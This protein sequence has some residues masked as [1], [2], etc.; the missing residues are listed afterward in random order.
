MKAL[1]FVCAL[2][3]ALVALPTRSHAGE[4]SGNY[5]N[6][7][8]LSDGSGGGGCAGTM[9]SFRESSD[10]SA[11]AHFFEYFYG[12]GQPGFGFYAYVNSRSYTCM[13]APGS[14]VDTMM[15]RYA[16]TGFGYFW[17]NWDKNGVC[18]QAAFYVGSD[19]R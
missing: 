2:A 15:R 18:T 14:V 10:S 11:M 4:V 7:W 8:L 9:T 6:C 12:S 16:A 1:S 13:P 5:A 3:V 17:L 19:Y